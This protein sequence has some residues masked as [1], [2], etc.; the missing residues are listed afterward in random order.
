MKIV[1]IYALA[2]MIVCGHCAADPYEGMRFGP[3]EQRALLQ[4]HANVDFAQKTACR[5]SDSRFAELTAELTDLGERLRRMLQQP[6][7]PLVLQAV[8]FPNQLALESQDLLVST[9]NLLNNLRAKY[10]SHA[11]EGSVTDAVIE[12]FGIIERGLQAAE[13]E[14]VREIHA[15]LS[16]TSSR[17]ITLKLSRLLDEATELGL[18]P[19]DHDIFDHFH[20]IPHLG[21]VTTSA[22]ALARTIPDELRYYDPIYVLLTDG[23]HVTGQEQVIFDVLMRVAA[24]RRD[25]SP[26]KPVLHTLIKLVIL[27]NCGGCTDPEHIL[28]EV[29]ITPHITHLMRSDNAD[30][31]ANAVRA[32]CM[33]LNQQATSYFG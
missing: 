27:S 8:P 18:V 4:I 16:T 22:F 5:F 13:I 26:D 19:R 23:P 31:I 21:E 3:G 7:P 29:G 2:S 17:I 32:T 25:R 28:R 12:L 10:V 20:N 1:K 9:L 15:S 6:S 30:K 11:T 14:V 24:V 33:F